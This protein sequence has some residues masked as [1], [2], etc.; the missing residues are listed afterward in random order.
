MNTLTSRVPVNQLK[1][2]GETSDYLHLRRDN[3]I[4]FTDL[5]GALCDEGAKLLDREKQLRKLGKLVL[6]SAWVTNIGKNKLVII[7]M[8]E[9]VAKATKWETLVEATCALLSVTLKLCDTFESETCKIIICSNKV[10]TL[11]PGQ[12]NDIHVESNSCAISGQKQVTKI[13]NRIRQRY[14]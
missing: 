13:Y 10:L 4:V 9:R 2:V 6:A 8:K 5:S 1:N 12:R 11:E 3:L 7:P 14:Y